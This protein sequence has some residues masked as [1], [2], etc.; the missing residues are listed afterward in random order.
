MKSLKLLNLL[1]ETVGCD[2]KIYSGGAKKG[3]PSGGPLAWL[4]DLTQVPDLGGEEAAGWT[5]L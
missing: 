2:E 3:F 4:S 1:N 5:A